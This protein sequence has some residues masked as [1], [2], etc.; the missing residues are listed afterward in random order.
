MAKIKGLKLTESEVSQTVDLNELF[1]ANF[2]GNSGL[3]QAIGQA[4]VDKILERTSKGIGVDG[5][6]L[7]KFSAK[8]AYSEE[9][10]DSL[11]FKAFGKSNSKVNME[12]TGQMLGTMDILEQSRGKIK[13]GWNDDVENAKAYNHNEGITVPKRRFFGL[14]DSE[15]KEIKSEF[16]DRVREETKNLQSE[17]DSIINEIIGRISRNTFNFGGD[18]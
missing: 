1:G 7:K 10:K 6:N 17:K 18:E 5:K 16:I 2:T 9:Y 3:A 11:E 8:S 15:L 13:I 4:M 14:N 12:L